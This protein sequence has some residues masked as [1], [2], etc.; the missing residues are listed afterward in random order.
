MV[1]TD[2]VDAWTS[3]GW[4]GMGLIAGK[5]GR[6]EYGLSINMVGAGVECVGGLKTKRA[7]KRGPA[8]AIKRREGPGCRPVNLSN[9]G[10]CCC[11]VIG[12]AF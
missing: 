4:V 6:I 11:V 2:W 5:D 1:E 3:V 8:A 9:Q 10:T 12:Q 7:S